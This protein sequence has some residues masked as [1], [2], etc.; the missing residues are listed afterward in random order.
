MTPVVPTTSPLPVAV[1]RAPG[2]Y[3]GGLR[4]RR[5]AR[6]YRFVFGL[7]RLDFSSG[8]GFRMASSMDATSNA[9]ISRSCFAHQTLNRVFSDGLRRKLSCVRD[10]VVGGLSEEGSVNTWP[11]KSSS[12]S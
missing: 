1:R 8:G 5:A 12:S 7:P 3:R 4:R 11:E 6:G 10:P 9:L 2:R